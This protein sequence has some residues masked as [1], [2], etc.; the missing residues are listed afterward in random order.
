MPGKIIIRPSHIKTASA[1]AVN[2]ASGFLFAALAFP[3][4]TNSLLALTFNLVFT[5]IYTW[6]AVKL[7][8]YLENL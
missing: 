4:A 5:T 1:I 7:E 2:L 6:I 3:L 8:D